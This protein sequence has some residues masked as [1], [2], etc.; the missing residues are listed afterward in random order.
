M[1]ISYQIILSYKKK[2]T[3]VYKYKSGL[4]VVK[5]RFVKSTHGRPRS[6]SSLE[7]ACYDSRNVN[8]YVITSLSNRQKYFS[9]DLTLDV[10]NSKRYFMNINKYV[11]LSTP[12]L[13]VR[14]IVFLL[15]SAE[16]TGN[17]N[18]DRSSCP[19]HKRSVESQQ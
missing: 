2:K 6:Q 19:T 10:Y 16:S 1:D 8:R 7:H 12:F 3:C 13:Y 5:F 14:T 17:I 18:S 9:S 4:L 11:I 15:K